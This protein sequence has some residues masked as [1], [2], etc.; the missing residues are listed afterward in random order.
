[1]RELNQLEME[2]VSGGAIWVIPL[3]IATFDLALTG[4]LY[5]YMSTME[6]LASAES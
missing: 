6:Y 2:N 4:V 3:A 1:M 5:G